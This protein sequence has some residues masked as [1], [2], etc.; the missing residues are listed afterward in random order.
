MIN[1]LSVFKSLLYALFVYL[2]I[3]TGT[4]IVLFVLMTLDSFLGIFKA[5]RLG[6]KFSFKVL[7]WGMVSK[8]SVLI[9]PMILALMGKGLS[10]DFS[11]FVVAVL[12]IIIVSEGISCVTNILSIKTKKQIENADYVTK[13]LQGVRNGLI[14][15]LEKNFKIIDKSTKTK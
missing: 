14:S 2:G 1:Y 6:K 4:V 15:V 13:L 5:L 10:F 8:L 12:N 11:Y 7:G 9:I 3:K